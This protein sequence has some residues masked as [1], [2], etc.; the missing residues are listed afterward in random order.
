MTVIISTFVFIGQFFNIAWLPI[1]VGDNYEDQ[2]NWF[3]LEGMAIILTMLLN[4]FLPIIAEVAD[5]AKR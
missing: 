2:R 1:L 5:Y 4:A 3:K